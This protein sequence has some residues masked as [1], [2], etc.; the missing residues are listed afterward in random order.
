MSQSL[1]VFLYA[2][3]SFRHLFSTT[4]SNSLSLHLS[5]WSNGFLL[6]SFHFLPL[7]TNF[8]ITIN[9]F[10]LPLSFS[11]LLP[12]ASLYHPSI[13]I[14]L[15]LSHYLLLSSHSIYKISFCILFLAALPDKRNSGGD[16]ALCCRADAHHCKYS[17]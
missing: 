4:Y 17:R 5:S 2:Y 14:S 9:C 7:S 11:I 16:S 10:F 12:F 8:S 13:Y 6:F 3:R 15:P 1:S